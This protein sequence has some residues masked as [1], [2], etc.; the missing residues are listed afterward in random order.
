MGRFPEG[1]RNAKPSAYA[2]GIYSGH[3][4]SIAELMTLSFST[5]AVVHFIMAFLLFYFTEFWIIFDPSITGP[6]EHEVYWFWKYLARYIEGALPWVILAYSISNRDRLKKGA[7][8]MIASMKVFAVIDLILWGNYTQ[9]IIEPLT[10]IVGFSYTL[11]LW[12]FLW[13]DKPTS[14]TV[15]PGKVYL[16]YRSP[17]RLIELIG[18]WLLPKW[19]GSVFVYSEGVCYGFRDRVFTR[20]ELEGKIK[21]RRNQIAREIKGFSPDQ[22]AERL[23]PYVGIRWNLFH[24]CYWVSR[25]AQRKN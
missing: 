9:R 16:I 12:Y 18:S 19:S 21:L 17:V 4:L 6:G 5:K 8:T 20:T 1:W 3:P 11:A 7:Y 23:R 22:V 25:K 15:E 10:L 14:D 2:L 13:R 24:S